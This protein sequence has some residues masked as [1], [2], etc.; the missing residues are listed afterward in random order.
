MNA[1][2]FFKCLSDPTRLQCVFLIYTRGEL[3]VCDLV[4]LIDE[5][6]PKVSRHLA[7]LRRC[8]VL[9]DNKSEQW[10]FYSINPKMPQWAKNVLAE[11]ENSKDGKLSQ[12][13]KKLR[14][15]Q[16]QLNCC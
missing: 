10:V 3:C 2:E 8:E 14:K 7:Q 9:I 16:Q 6:Q 12:L 1:V 13:K 5:S 4:S 15:F 11:L